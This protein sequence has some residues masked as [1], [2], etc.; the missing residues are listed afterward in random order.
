[1]FGWI[2]GQD[3]TYHLGKTA[4]AV[5]AVWQKARSDLAKKP[6]GRRAG[7]AELD[8]MLASALYT[9][10]LWSS[11]ADALVQY[12]H[13]DPSGLLSI[14]DQFALQSVDPG[15]LAYNCMDPGW[16]RSWSAWHWDT[17]VA[18]RRAPQFAWMNTW[19]SAP[20]AFWP[21]A[22]AKQHPIG[23]AVPILLIQGRLDPA[24]PV[25][26]ARRMHA[27]LRG[28]RLLLE[29]GGN[30][31]SYLFQQNPC[32][33]SRAEKYLLTGQLPTDTNCPA[34]T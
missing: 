24:T 14:T 18:D 26:G 31:A 21:V 8:D 2:A 9:D 4:T 28:S 6:A 10:D 33:D 20:C 11:L 7:V 19:Y 13:G 29:N 27:V 15:Q 32:I 34:S 5:G 25:I 1:M 16:P 17:T 12:R 3:K 23:S 22:P 30:H